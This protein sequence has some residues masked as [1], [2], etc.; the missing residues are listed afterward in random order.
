MISYQRKFYPFSKILGWSSSRYETFRLCKRKYYYVYY[1]KF[2]TENPQEKILELKNLKSIPLTIGTVVH[3][4]IKTILK[5]YKKVETPVDENRLKNFIF[6]C[7]RTYYKSHSFLEHY[8][9]LNTEDFS[10]QLFEEVFSKIEV[11]LNSQSLSFILSESMPYKDYWVIE[12]EGF[13]ETRI[14]V[15]KAYCKVDFAFP[16]G[17]NILIYDWKTGKKS[18]FKHK[19]QMVGYAYWASEA[20]DV[21]KSKIIPK[22]AYLNKVIEED[23]I[24]VTEND[25]ENFP[26][27]VK[28]DSMEMYDFCADVEKNI[29]KKIDKFEKNENLQICMNCNFRELCF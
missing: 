19:N 29:P 26:D 2:D 14:D 27:K 13:G 7:T 10:D 4:I 22:I 3:D 23:P 16:I 20:F 8:Y 24:N 21:P 1:S 6:D 12:P 11:F 17:E 15:M 9:D 5:R 25:I 28:K 18:K